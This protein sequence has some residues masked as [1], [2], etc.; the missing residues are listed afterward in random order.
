MRDFSIIVLFLAPALL[1]KVCMTKYYF[2]M[3]VAYS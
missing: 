3:I 2:V 1:A